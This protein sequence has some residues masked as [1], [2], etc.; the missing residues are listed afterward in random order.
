MNRNFSSNYKRR[1]ASAAFA[2]VMALLTAA[3]A[4]AEERSEAD[5]TRINDRDAQTQKLTPLDQSNTSNDTAIVAKI[6]ST[7]SDDKSLSVNARNVKV[8]VRDGVVTL[9]GPVENAAEKARVAAIAKGVAGVTSVLNE[10][11]TKH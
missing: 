2:V 8:I 6:R 1:S 9:R 10:I 5:N 7:I 3:T 11:D 4:H